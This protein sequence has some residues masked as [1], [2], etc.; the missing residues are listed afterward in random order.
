MSDTNIFEH[1]FDGEVSYEGVLADWVIGK[2]N[3]WREHY[4]SNYS[5]KHE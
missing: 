2:C 1:E 5:Q 3:D 4:E